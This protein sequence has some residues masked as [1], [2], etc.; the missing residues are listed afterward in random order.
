MLGNAWSGLST[1]LSSNVSAGE[2]FGKILTT[3]VTTITTA[4]KVQ[5]LFKTLLGDSADK[6]TLTSIKTAI[7]TALNGGLS[8]SFAAAS[9]AVKKFGLEL[10][11]SPLMPFIVVLTALGAAI[12]GITAIINANKK[13][14]E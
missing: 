7:Q 4:T 9:A 2:K 10:L 3:L 13:A 1:T 14:E 8:A 12:A 5:G 6:L 11:K